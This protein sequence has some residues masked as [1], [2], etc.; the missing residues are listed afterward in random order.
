M[1]ENAPVFG[2]VVEWDVPSGFVRWMVIG[3]KEERGGGT[4]FALLIGGGTS[5]DLNQVRN[6]GL[7][8]DDD[9]PHPTKRWLTDE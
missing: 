9:Y 2:D 1:S 7:G 4:Y 5:H 8:T 6:I 3:P